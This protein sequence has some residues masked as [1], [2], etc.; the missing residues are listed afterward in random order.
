MSTLDDVVTELGAKPILTEPEQ[1]ALLAAHLDAWANLQ[2][3]LDAFLVDALN[4]GIFVKRV[5][6][7]V[8]DGGIACPAEA[9]TF[10]LK[11]RDGFY[12]VFEPGMAGERI[13]VSIQGRTEKACLYRVGPDWWASYSGGQ[14][15]LTEEVL[16]VIF[17]DI[18]TQV[19]IL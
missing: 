4:Q 14:A 19:G 10:D 16:G 2:T 1:Q 13:H 11:L 6:G 5:R 17:Q 18:L 3:Q 12:I 7:V 15:L 9:I 8:L